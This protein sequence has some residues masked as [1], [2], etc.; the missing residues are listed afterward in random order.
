MG[1]FNRFG[2][3]SGKEGSKPSV[4]KSDVKHTTKPA[5]KPENENTQVQIPVLKDKVETH[6]ETGPQTKIEAK[7]GANTPFPTK[8][9]ALD[10][11]KHEGPQKKNKDAFKKTERNIFDKTSKQ[12]GQTLKDIE[13]RA[14]RFGL[15]QSRAQAFE[16]GTNASNDRTGKRLD[17]HT[18]L[19]EKRGFANSQPPARSGEMPGA[20]H[21]HSA[22]GHREKFGHLRIKSMDHTLTPLASG[23][24]CDL[25]L[26]RPHSEYGKTLALK[27]LKP[28]WMELEHMR[29]QFA[30]EAQI[31]KN[32]THSHLPKFVH[33]GHTETRSY[34][35][36]EYIPGRSLMS[37]AQQQQVFGQRDALPKVIQILLSILNQIHYLH[38]KPGGIVHGDISAENVILSSDGVAHL[39]DFG[40]AHLRRTPPP[41]CYQWIGKPSYLS[42]EQARGEAWTVASDIYQIGILG[43]ELVAGKRWL[44]GKSAKEKMLQAAN[45]KSP[46]P[47]FIAPKA[48]LALSK[49][50]A[51][52]LTSDANKR[53]TNVGELI[54]QL[55]RANTI[56]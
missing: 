20:R 53:P 4:T 45:I 13:A 36:Y 44:R 34:L 14:N 52:C 55:K 22:D 42:P 8:K 28:D 27:M 3:K 21:R 56:Y 49:W 30:F 35:A 48:P 16:A 6:K 11:T 25:Y 38:T 23:G 18:A 19:K 9:L 7:A 31:L 32:I 50:I 51:S 33:F 41:G 29:R 54:S 43:Y 15:A 47:D 10:I 24:V 39:T 17:G 40:C 1:I 2:N 12:T 46:S 5:T 26:A 37:Y